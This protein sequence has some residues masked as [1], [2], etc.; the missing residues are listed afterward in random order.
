MS[1]TDA[2]QGHEVYH[3]STTNADLNV[4][5]SAENT[6]NR[7]SSGSEQVTK[8]NGRIPVVKTSSTHRRKSSGTEPGVF[9]RLSI[10]RSASTNRSRSSTNT[11][12]RSSDKID[13]VEDNLFRRTSRVPYLKSTARKALT[14]T[15]KVNLPAISANSGN[16]T[17]KSPMNLM[18][19][20]SGFELVPSSV[21][22]EFGRMKAELVCKENEIIRLRADQ[23]SK[24]DEELIEHGVVALSEKLIAA[25]N[26]AIHKVEC[27]GRELELRLQETIQAM[28][29]ELRLSKDRCAVLELQLATLKDAAEATK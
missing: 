16:E 21:R 6:E 19:D 15:S 9:D 26:Q 29:N 1:D 3:E 28:T 22:D 13:S 8:A 4:G 11:S 10:P 27:R 17:R 7:I 18:A 24:D 12:G 5:A 25:H 2:T 23:V 14:L 20:T